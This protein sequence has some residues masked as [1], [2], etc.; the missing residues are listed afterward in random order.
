MSRISKIVLLCVGVLLVGFGGLYAFFTL[1][2][3][4]APAPVQLSATSSTTAAQA[5]SPPA[6]P[7]P[8]QQGL[9]GTWKT[10]SGDE[11]FVG[12][13]VNEKLANLPVRSDAVGRTSTVTGTMTL[14]AT[15]VRS[16]EV[17]ADLRDLRSDEGRRD[18]A[19]RTRGLESNRFPTATFTSSAPI[20]IGTVP[21]DGETFRGQAQ[22]RLSLHGVTKDV[23]VSIEARR[24]GNT[25]EVVGSLPISFADYQIEPPNVANFVSVDD[26]GV[27]EFRLLF[28]KV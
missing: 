22:G 3:R 20:E 21:R 1:K 5:G 27:I 6:T 14:D 2:N 8:A 24:M 13:R 4:D 25:I 9:D 16:V 7:A 19:I 23:T 26:K 10:R 17:V 11:S 15:T 28:D 18:N 12:Y